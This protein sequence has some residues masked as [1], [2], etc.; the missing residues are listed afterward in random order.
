[1]Y[2]KIK[3]FFL[4]NKYK[5][6]KFL[7]AV[8][9]GV[10]SMVLLYILNKIINKNISVCNCFFNLTNNNLHTLLV[11]NY[12]YNNNIKFFFK[13]FNTL[14]YIKKKKISIQMG[15]RILRYNLFNNIIK[16]YN[17]N[18]LITAHHIDDNIETFFINL[19]RGSSIYGLKG[20]KSFNKYIIRPYLILNINKKNI[21]KYA[22]NNNIKWINDKSNF[23]NIYL[24]NKIRNII[25]PILKLNFK[26]FYIYILKTLNKLNIEYN[27]I[28]CYINYI[29]NKI[30]IKKKILN[31]YYLYIKISNLIKIKYYEYILYRYFIR[32][33]FHNIEIFKKIPILRVGKNLYSN[34][35]KYKI[36]KDRG[37]IIFTKNIIIKIKKKINY[38]S[39]IY[40]NNIKIIF[41]LNKKKKII[42]KKKFI[43]INFDIIS[44]PLYIKNWEEG[45]NFIYKN[46]IIN[47]NK[48]FKK[49]N[50]SK[51]YKDKILFLVDINNTIL[52]S[53]NKILIYN[54]TYLIKNNTNK[55]LFFNFL[56]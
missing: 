52:S 39:K 8:S 7:I 42:Y 27:F 1:M 45:D 23:K 12:C 19:L 32:Y 40:I 36:I 49:L 16:K 22:I 54:N 46:K 30:L 44:P 43:Y 56:K 31:I 9:G 41:N 37:K 29:I 5:N 10:D 14:K 34:N 50:I 20:I 2:N 33:G 48:I 51:F 47:I 55:I 4:N 11:F 21:I 25:I 38:P 53:L 15:A 3:S 18:Y 28:K 24:R 6:K 17:Y 13:K 35:Y 26:N